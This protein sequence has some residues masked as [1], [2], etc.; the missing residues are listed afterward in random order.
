[1]AVETKFLVALNLT[2]NEI[3]NVNLQNLPEAP[4]VTSADVGRI[5][6]NTVEKKPKFWNGESWQDFGQYDTAIRV[7]TATNPAYTV[8]S[9]GVFVW[10]ISTVAE[11][12]NSVQSVIVYDN[13][14]GE[15]VYPNIAVVG[16]ANPD[17]VI[18]IAAPEGTVI[19]ENTYTAR[20]I[21]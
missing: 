10:T 20:Y 14:T 7:H 5:Y 17:I 15:Q 2:G 4:V 6:Y 9:N 11:S 3:R 13:S 12:R 18:T 1:M 8:T 16:D 21:H 19:E